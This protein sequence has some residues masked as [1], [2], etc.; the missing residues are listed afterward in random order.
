MNLYFDVR[1]TYDGELM[2]VEKKQDQYFILVSA[3]SP[4]AAR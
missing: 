3:Q 1:L 2:D 4:S